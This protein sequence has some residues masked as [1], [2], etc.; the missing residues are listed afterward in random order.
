MTTDADHRRMA[1]IELDVSGRTQMD[2]Q[3]VSAYLLLAGVIFMLASFP[4][5]FGREIYGTQD[6]LQRVEIIRANEARWA[7]SQTLIAISL[8]LT[9]GGF[10]V[11]NTWLYGKADPWPF[12]LGAGAMII[13]AISGV[14]FVYRQTVDPMGSYQGA[15]HAFEFVY[16]WLS[17]GGLLLFGVA[18]L[19][20]GLPTWLG[21]LTVGAT[22]IYAIFFA[23]TDTGFPTP[24]LVFVL[25]LVIGVA[26]LRLSVT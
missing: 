23:A 11:L 7:V 13:G 25:S 2:S 9:A 17:V 24:W 10:F 14:I 12:T 20:A 16:Y 8:L 21:Y 1:K 6:F 22:A 5:G 15:Y 4:V 3:R 26:L 18:F 19:Q